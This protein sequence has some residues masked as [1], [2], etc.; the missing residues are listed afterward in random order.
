[1]DANAIKKDLEEAKAAVEAE[2]SAEAAKRAAEVQTK[3]EVL[4]VQA[5]AS[6]R[7]VSSTKKHVPVKRVAGKAMTYLVFQGDTYNEERDGQFI[8][9]PKFTK[10]GRTMHH[11]DRLLDVREGDIFF[12]C[13]DGYIK[14]ISR[15]KSPCEDS[16]RPD[17]TSGDWA[18][19]EKDGRRVDC[20]Y[21]ILKY[22]L[23]HG[24]HKEKILEYC[25]VKYAPF[26]KDGN[27]NMGYLYDLNQNLAAYFIQ[28]I[29]K[30]NPEVIDFDYLKFILVK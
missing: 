12:H 7:K 25:N 29:A 2:K 28:E 21:H 17:H 6:G 8:W 18:N 10:D 30:K 11:W 27:G 4:R 14:A 24:A 19:W 23:K 9:A 15:V 13:S 22:P 1:M 26:D 20:D 5:A 3:L 16:A